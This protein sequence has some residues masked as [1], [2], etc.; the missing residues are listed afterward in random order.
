[1]T[2]LINTPNEKKMTHRNR[3]LSPVQLQQCARRAF[4][5]SFATFDSAPGSDLNIKHFY[6][7]LGTRF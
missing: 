1:M 2:S 7:P 5:Y 4:A 6:C 3:Y